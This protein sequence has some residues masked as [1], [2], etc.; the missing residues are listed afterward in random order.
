MKYFK[1]LLAILIG[2]MLI[3]GCNRQTKKESQQKIITVSI[4]PIKNI[5]DRLTDNQYKVNVMIPKEIG[6]SDYSPTAQ[7]M[8]DLSLSGSYVAVG[9]LDFELTWGE[10][11][12]DTNPQ[13]QWVDI[14]EGLDL[15]SGHHHCDGHGHDDEHNHSHSDHSHASSFDPHFWMSPKTAIEMAGNI[16]RHLIAL[17]ATNSEAIE[18]NFNTLKEELEQIGAEFED[19][20]NTNDEITFMIYHPALGYLARDY[21]FHQLEIEQDGKTPTPSGLK[22]IIKEAKE[23]KVKTLFIQTNFN[24]NNAK[25]AAQEIGAQIVQINPESEDWTGELRLIA[26]HLKEQQ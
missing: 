20:A 26:R 22:N 7:Q 14:S 2:L 10:R 25:V 11:L 3:T 12:R 1:S 5:I 18:R 13:M 6:H 21:G 23:K 24:V 17:D 15:I 8:K 16:K 4:F 19:I 9:P